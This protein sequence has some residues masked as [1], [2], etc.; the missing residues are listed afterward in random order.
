MAKTDPLTERARLMR[1]SM[2]PSEARFWTVVRRKGLGFRFRRQLVVGNAIADFACAE[3]RLIVEFD[4]SQHEDDPRD[5]RRDRVLI[6]SGWR[7]LRFWNEQMLDIEFVKEAVVA[8][9]LD[10]RL[11]VG[12][13]T[14]VVDDGELHDAYDLEAPYPGLGPGP[15]PPQAGDRGE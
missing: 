12:V 8:M 4:G 2:T 9:L 6:G 3:R 14:R 13:V 7:V 15:C 5:D 10:E 1:R 11:G